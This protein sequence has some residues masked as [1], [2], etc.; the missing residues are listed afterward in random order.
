M[1]SLKKRH[2]DLKCNITMDAQK[3][4]ANWTLEIESFERLILKLRALGRVLITVLCM[5]VS[6]LKAIQKQQKS[7][8]LLL[9]LVSYLLVH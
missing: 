8:Q 7:L 1:T 4:R 9:L 2:S 5:N 3:W 6:M